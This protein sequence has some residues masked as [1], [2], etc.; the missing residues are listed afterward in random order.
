MGNQHRACLLETI[1]TRIPE[2]LGKTA[3]LD[4]FI[5]KLKP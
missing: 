1:A 4:N 3:N 5:N 2:D